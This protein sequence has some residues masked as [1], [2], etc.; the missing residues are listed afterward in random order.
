MRKNMQEAEYLLWSRL[1][2]K[3]LGVKFRRQQPI[4]S[5]IVDFF[6]SEKRLIIELDGAQH[7]L[8]QSHDCKRTAIL[9][10]EEYR[11]IRFWNN[12]VFIAMDAVLEKISDFLKTPH[13]SAFTCGLSSAAP[14]QGGS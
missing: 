10:A 4:G 11:V 6:C 8:Q 9:E 5:Y 13:A 3:Q 14:P 2:R 1:N 7:K 12:D